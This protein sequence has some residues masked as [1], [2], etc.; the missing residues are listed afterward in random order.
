MLKSDLKQN[1]FIAYF[2]VIEIIMLKYNN[3]V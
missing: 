2:G 1:M 3:N